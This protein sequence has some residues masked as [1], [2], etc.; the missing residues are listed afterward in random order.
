MPVKRLKEALDKHKMK[1][2][3]VSHSL[4]YTAQEI[5]ATAHVPGKEL[6]KTVMVRVDGK[7]QM[8]VLPA[9]RQI[10]F[11]KLK[12]AL[13]AKKADLA[14]EEEFRGLCPDCELGAMPPFGS[15]YGLPVMVDQSLGEDEDI[16][17]NAGTHRELVKMAFEDFINIEKPDMVD[18]SKP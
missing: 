3:V 2:V 5:A 14:T 15:L 11:S 1:Y 6:A 4:A 16:Y 8:A 10:D 17:F 9:S 13:Q 18:F 12:K 7:I